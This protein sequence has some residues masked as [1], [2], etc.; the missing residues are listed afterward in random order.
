MQL[1]GK[2][3][4]YEIFPTDYPEAFR[5]QKEMDIIEGETRPKK[6]NQDEMRERLMHIMAERFTNY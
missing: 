6:P 5:I 1:D 3:T 4:S 2:F